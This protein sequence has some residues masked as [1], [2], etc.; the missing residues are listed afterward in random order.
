MIGCDGIKS[1][2]RQALFGTEDPASFPQYTHKVAYRGLVPM[3]KAVDILGK[4]KANNFHHHVGPGAHLTHYPVANHT[5]LN[6]VVF[7]SDP[8]PWPQNVGMVTEGSR[9]DI[10]DFMQG[11]HPTVL[12]LVKLLPDTLIKWGL[13]DTGDFPAAFYNVGN[14]CIAGDAAHASSPH[15]GAGAC[16]GVS[17][18]HEFMQPRASCLRLRLLTPGLDRR[19]PVS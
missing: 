12:G 7:L 13:F 15:H 5:A 11:W 16:V 2:V 19:C 6:V 17:K 14:V 1:R 3:D 18:M 9:K 10:E 4:W 8:E